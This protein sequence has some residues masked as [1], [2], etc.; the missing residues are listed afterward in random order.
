MIYGR[1]DV[2]LAASFPEEKDSVLA[3][4]PSGFDAVYS[5]P[6]SRC[7]QLAAVISEV[8]Q[9]N[10]ALYELNFGDWEG[11]TW[12]TI[13]RLQCDT[14]MDDFVHLAPPNGE[15]MLD[16][17]QRIL[18]FWEYLLH[19]CYHRV[20]IIT[21]GGVIRI[22]LAHY[23]DLALRDAFTLK[24]GMGEVVKLSIPSLYMEQSNPPYLPLKSD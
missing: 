4:I 15:T 16:M 14:W 22:I 3:Q 21:H 7:T 11:K 20:A 12:D 18:V 23:R 8:Y 2:P 1:T 10:K 9:E 13:D 17:Q 5:S 24:I 19:Q 6:S